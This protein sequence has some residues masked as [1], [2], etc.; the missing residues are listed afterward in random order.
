[1]CGPDGRPRSAN[2]GMG[3]PARAVTPEDATCGESLSTGLARRDRPE[4]LSPVDSQGRRSTI[5]AAMG[6]DWE[7]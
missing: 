7:S 2:D 6:L 3:G 4:F 1:M 5:R